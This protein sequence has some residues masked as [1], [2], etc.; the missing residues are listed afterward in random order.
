MTSTEFLQSGASEG[1]PTCKCSFA[2]IKLSQALAYRGWTPL[3]AYLLASVSF[4]FCVGT[5]LTNRLPRRPTLAHPKTLFT[6]VHHKTLFLV[7][8]YMA[9][10]Y[11]GAPELTF[12]TRILALNASGG[13]MLRYCLLRRLSSGIGTGEC[14]EDARYR[15][16]PPPSYTIDSHFLQCMRTSCNAR[17]LLVVYMHA[18]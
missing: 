18:R 15:H 14:V 8:S 6:L 16:A 13:A 12:L 7:G 5:L 10:R 1:Q 2:L 11:V 9:S 4:C 17:A 3:Q